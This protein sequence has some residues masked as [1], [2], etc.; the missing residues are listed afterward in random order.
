MKYYT[1]F[2][3]IQ[4]EFGLIIGNFDGVHLGHRKLLKNFLDK[5][6]ELEVIPVLLTFKPHPALFFNP[7]K[8]N[9]RISLDGRK[10]DLLFQLGLSHVVEMNFDKNLQTK[11]SREFLE[12]IVFSQKGLRY[13]AIGHDFALGA[14]KED[15]I[16]QS[17]ELSEKHNVVLTQESS[18]LFEGKP[19]SSTRIREMIKSGEIVKVNEALA[20]N[21]K[22]SGQVI[23]G[24]G[25]GTKSLFPTLNI[26]P[27]HTQI[28]PAHGVYLTYVTIKG[29]VYRSLT[30]IGIRPTVDDDPS[31][32]IETH[33]LD[34][35][36]EVYGELVHLEFVSKIRDE[37][38]FNSFEELKKQI[39][40]D[41]NYAINRF[42]SLIRIHL[43]LIG[44]PLNHSESPNI[45]EKLLDH[46]LS[47]DLLDYQDSSLIPSAE[48]LLEKYNGVSIT[49]P[50]KMAFLDELDS[51]GD[52][53][54]AYNTLLVKDD[55]CFGANTDYL[56]CLEIIENLLNIHSIPEVIILGDGSMASMLESILKKKNLKYEIVSR[57]N[58]KLKS[59]DKIIDDLNAHTLVINSCS[60]EYSF[61]FKSSTDLIVWDLNYKSDSETWFQDFP[62][63]Q[64]MDGSELLERQAKNALS[65]WNLGE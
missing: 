49:S 2:D 50:Y 38:K 61:K 12:Q 22:I 35:S 65:F 56:G 4:G 9:F 48:S 18:F 23:R 41:I 37:K 53:D 8:G 6:S 11:S 14:G 33:V 15:S 30:N 59:I 54:G 20:R 64:Y 16:S 27:D 3:Q 28:I 1:S 46:S 62:N 45:Y 32:T 5:C 57:K 42:D 24:K 17:I 19:I 51:L 44:H 39:E 52:Y 26:E 40:D 58:G 25:I 47:Y 31:V 34:F 60:R 36:E 13:L 21:F 63:I 7:D 43:A 29:R 55:K 10:R